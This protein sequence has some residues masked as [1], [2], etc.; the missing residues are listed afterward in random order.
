MPLAKCNIISCPSTEF[1]SSVVNKSHGHGNGAPQNL[2]ALITTWPGTLCIPL[3]TSPNILSRSRENLCYRLNVSLQNSYVEILPP[4]VVVIGGE[5][6]GTLGHEGR[7][8]I[9]GTN[10]FIWKKLHRAPSSLLP[11]EDGEQGSRSSPGTGSAGAFFLDFIA[12]R[13]VRN[14]CCLSHSVCGTLLQKPKLTNRTPM[15][16]HHNLCHKP[17]HHLQKFPLA[18]L[19]MMMIRVIIVLWER[20]LRAG[21]GRS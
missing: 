1:W 17:V 20:F 3:S 14:K 7:A 6:F 18:L 21:V 5:V 11:C 4:K 13:I 15:N 10:T 8:L 16:H 19:I 12:S 9:I 2:C